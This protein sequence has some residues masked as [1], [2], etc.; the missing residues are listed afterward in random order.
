MNVFY[1][2]NL[3]PV[4]EAIKQ[5]A[6]DGVTCPSAEISCVQQKLYQFMSSANIIYF[7]LH[8]DVN[9]RNLIFAQC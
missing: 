5:L 6:T 7:W 1:N 8:F 2:Y 4:C 3:A 9:A